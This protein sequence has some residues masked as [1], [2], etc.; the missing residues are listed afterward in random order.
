VCPLITNDSLTL[1]CKK[2]DN[3]IVSFG[4]KVIAQ[5]LEEYLRLADS[6]KILNLTNENTKDF[7]NV[8][9]IQLN[10]ITN[11]K[12]KLYDQILSY[13]QKT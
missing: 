3:N 13:S 4:Q 1:I 5:Y 12:T 9:K 11:G 2:L 6:N 7:L 10:L 8:V